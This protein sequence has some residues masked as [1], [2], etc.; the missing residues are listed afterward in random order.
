M[1]EDYLHTLKGKQ[2]L[3]RGMNEVVMKFLCPDDQDNKD[4]D[5]KNQENRD[6]KDKDQENKD[7]EKKDQENKD[8]E[9]KELERKLVPIVVRLVK[10]KWLH[11]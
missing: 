9:Y 2:S 4:Q 7:R 6:Q 11:P 3:P 5:D 1:P 10:Q 8:Q